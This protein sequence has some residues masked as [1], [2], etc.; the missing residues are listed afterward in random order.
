MYI[1]ESNAMCEKFLCVFLKT[2]TY[3][4]KIEKRSHKI[5]EVRLRNLNPDK[6]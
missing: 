1:R 3:D 6:P 4:I 5:R 2:E